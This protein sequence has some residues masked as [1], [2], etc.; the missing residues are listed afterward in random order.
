MTRGRKMT[1]LALCAVTLALLWLLPGCTNNDAPQ[2]P[3]QATQQAAVDPRTEERA[4]VGNLIST[5]L[6]FRMKAKGYPEYYC[7][8]YVQEQTGELVV[9]ATDV[10]AIKADFLPLL[11]DYETVAYTI[12]KCG[13]SKTKLMALGVTIRDNAQTLYAQGIRLVAINY[14]VD[15]CMVYVSVEDLTP[16]KEQAILSLVGSD[17]QFIRVYDSGPHDP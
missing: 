3:T 11:A 14:P 10:E 15:A 4:R 5:H 16:E 6:E 8:A 17:S 2:D 1:V 7:S 9:L 12:E 13:A